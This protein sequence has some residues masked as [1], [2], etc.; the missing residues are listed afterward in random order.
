MR[1]AFIPDGTKVDVY[2]NLHKNVYSVRA[3]TG[4]HAGRVI[5]H[6][7]RFNLQNADLVV[8][9]AGRAKVLAEKRKNVHAFARGSWINAIHGYVEPITYNPYEFDSFVVKA[10]GTPVHASELVSG[11]T[12]HGKARLG[13]TI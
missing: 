1:N 4:E 9:Q 2:W 13:A 12:D 11:W 8:H 10:T 6:V 7:D 3:R 5:A